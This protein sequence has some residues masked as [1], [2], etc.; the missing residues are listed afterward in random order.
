MPEVK[1]NDIDVLKVIDRHFEFETPE[2]INRV[3]ETFSKDVIWELPARN[4]RLTDP[5]KIVDQYHRIINGMIN[6]KMEVLHRFV[7]GN[8]VF[9][10]RWVYFTAGENN[11][12]DVKPGK[13]V[14]LRLVHYFEVTKD[15]ISREVGY[16]MWQVLED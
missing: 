7:S 4:L 3:V 11:V 15:K 14:K 9:D 6:P 2:L 12:W 16:E 10:D 8:K 13:K 1:M 5:A